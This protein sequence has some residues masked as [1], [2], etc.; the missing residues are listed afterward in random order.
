VDVEDAVSGPRL[1]DQLLPRHD[2]YYEN[3][4]WG[5]TVHVVAPKAVTALQARRQTT[6][7]APIGVGVAQAVVVEY[8][9]GGGGG[10]GGSGRSS[11]RGVL[12]ARSDER[13]DGAPAAF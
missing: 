3:V 2:V 5:H 10:G 9:G 1:H 8:S 11:S 12:M 6:T 13:K 4:T 7:P